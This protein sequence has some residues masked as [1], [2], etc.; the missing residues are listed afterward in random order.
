MLF[1][2]TLNQPVDLLDM[3]L[4]GFFPLPLLIELLRHAQSGPRA[5]K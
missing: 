1:A 3:F 4:H 5:Q 2:G